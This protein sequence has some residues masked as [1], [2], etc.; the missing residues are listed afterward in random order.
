METLPNWFWIIYYLFLLATLKTALSSLV[1]KQVLRIV[2]SFTIIFV[3]TIP[4]IGLI[5]SIERQDG[6]N[7]FE[8]FRGQLQQEEMWTIYSIVGYVYLLVWWGL[9]IRKEKIN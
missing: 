3:C 9:V 4:F 2:S 8:Y 7:E 6:L 5:H 1:K